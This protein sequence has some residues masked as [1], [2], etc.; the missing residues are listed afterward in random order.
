MGRPTKAQAIEITKRR[1]RAAQ[2]RTD[3]APW[4]KIADELGYGSPGAACQDVMRARQ[5]AM[6]EMR[7]NVTALRDKELALL[8]TLEEAAIA[9]LTRYHV[10]ISGGTI[11]RDGEPIMEIGDDGEPRA[12]IA[13][14][15]GAPL[16]DDSP[17]LAAIDRLV[18]VGESRRKLL[19]LDSPT[20]LEASGTIR[21]V[22][23]GPDGPLD[24]TA[25]T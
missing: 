19:G 3:G 9:V 24:M 16:E 2:M 4:W 10:T 1:A 12:L 11:I 18:K 13:E 5:A 22:I 25:L 17:V 14:G 21:Y 7:E 6:A 20:K 15:A 8:D 23:E